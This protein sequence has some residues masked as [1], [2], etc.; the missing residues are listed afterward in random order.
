MRRTTMIAGVLAAMLPVS[1]R[2]EEGEPSGP[3]E[4]EQ[5][6]PTRVTLKVL[7]IRGSTKGT[8]TPALAAWQKRLDAY[9]YTAYQL[10]QEQDVV[11][12]L[13]SRETVPLPGGRSL[14]VR[15]TKFEKSGKLRVHLH[16]LSNKQVKLVC[17]D[18]AIA[19][20][21]DLTVGGPRLEE[22]DALFILIRH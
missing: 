13:K 7:I 5:G 11:L 20:G 6:A 17:A 22:G 9:R 15:P 8:T 1:A 19:P 14:E 2:A 21:G 16:V 10:I 18:Y 4:V 12:D 3:P